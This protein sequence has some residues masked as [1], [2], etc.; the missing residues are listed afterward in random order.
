MAGP[1]DKINKL[2]KGLKNVDTSSAK[3]KK[4][5]DK[6]GK[7][8]NKIGTD[9]RTLKTNQEALVKQVKELADLYGKDFKSQAQKANQEINKQSAINQKIVDSN[10]KLISSITS[11]IT[12][13]KERSREE[14][15]AINMVLKQK[16][17]EEAERKREIASQKRLAA[18]RKKALEPLILARRRAER[19]G[20]AFTKGTKVQIEYNRALKNGGIIQKEYVRELNRL[21]AAE[22]R[23]RAQKSSLTE[24]QKRLNSSLGLGIRN[25]RNG[26]Q[27][28]SVFRSKL[29]LASFGVGLLSKATVDQ[30][31]A[32]GR[33]EGALRR[34]N[35]T[36]ISTGR[37]TKISGQEIQSYAG[38]LQKLTGVSDE[39]IMESS[40]LLLTFTN[41][42]E[43][44]KRAQ[45]VILDV[46]TALGQDLKS[47]TIQV[48]KALQDP[49]KGLSALSRVGIQ[50]TEVQK[51]QIIGFEQVG[52]TA[53]A[54]EVILKELEVQFG[55]LS[56][57]MRDTAE[58]QLLA[59][60]S[61]IGD[62]QEKIG[63]A[64]APTLIEATKALTKFVEGISADSISKVIGFATAIITV[65]AQFKIINV[66]FGKVIPLVKGLTFSFKALTA[67]MGGP[68][69]IAVKA[70]ALGVGALGFNMA[71]NATEVKKTNHTL[72][73]LKKHSDNARS[74][75]QIMLA[76]VGLEKTK[77][78]I[79]E[80]EADVKLLS[81][82]IGI[83]A[84]AAFGKLKNTNEKM[85]SSVKAINTMFQEGNVKAHGYGTELLKLVGIQFGSIT[86]KDLEKLEK[87]GLL[88]L[89]NQIK[90]LKKEQKDVEKFSR[91][92]EQILANP[93]FKGK[94]AKEF[95]LFFNAQDKLKKVMTKSE[96]T[97][98]RTGNEIDTYS[99]KNVDL[100]VATERLNI[101]TQMQIQNLGKIDE[102][103]QELINQ[104]AEKTVAMKKEQLVL[105]NQAQI[106]AQTTKAI[107][108]TTQAIDASSQATLGETLRVERA[109]AIRSKF[110]GKLGIEE[111]QLLELIEAMEDLA[112]AQ[113]LLSLDKEIKQLDG[114]AKV[115]RDNIKASDAFLQIEQRINDEKRK[116]LLD[117]QELKDLR[118]SLVKSTN[119]NQLRGF[120][121]Q[122][123]ALH[124][125]LVLTRRGIKLGGEEAQLSQMRIDMSSQL[126]DGNKE[127]ELAIEDIIQKQK[128]LNAEIRVQR[129]EEEIMQQ[130]RQSGQTFA[131][132]TIGATVSDTSLDVLDE[133]LAINSE[134]V[135]I[136]E[137]TLK[138]SLQK[139]ENQKQLIELE[140][141]AN[142]ISEQNIR[143]LADGT[144]L[145]G[146]K[147]IKQREVLDALGQEA[148]FLN[149]IKQQLNILGLSEIKRNDLVIQ[150]R[151]SL[152]EEQ[153]HLMKL[154]SVLSPDSTDSAI[155][156]RLK[157]LEALLSEGSIEASI[158]AI[159]KGLTS[160]SNIDLSI[161]ESSISPF[162]DTLSKINNATISLIGTRSQ[163][164]IDA[165]NAALDAEIEAEKAKESFKRSSARRQQRIL[166]ALESAQQAKRKKNFDDQKK[167]D[168]ANAKTSGYAAILSALAT[169]PWY[170]GLINAGIAGVMMDENIQQ[171]KATEFALGGFING[172][173]HSMGGVPIEAE[174]GEYIIRKSAVQQYGKEFF[175]S[176]NR[177]QS[178]VSGVPMYQNGGM[179]PRNVTSAPAQNTVI[180][181]QFSGNVLSEEFIVSEAIPIIK[182]S[183]RQSRFMMRTEDSNEYIEVVD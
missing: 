83:R 134:L 138:L 118:E 23:A 126:I 164:S 44:F 74:A 129:L 71:R 29:L 38:E 157:E 8:L 133:L 108:N 141:T 18:Q 139:I 178:T 96:Q 69:L 105:K 82:T 162:L 51:R 45:S 14:T 27:A 35:S 32:F 91:E 52:E 154:K 4:S 56:A 109:N 61:A 130:N 90:Q 143:I 135:G 121:L 67:V 86:K 22:E 34:V 175:D 137:D 158:D 125:Q 26:G 179:V 182:D 55:M 171:I 64:L 77:E 48:G 79:S 117:E 111:K 102:D 5:V 41:V 13:Q 49:I 128:Q 98:Q 89:V 75:L 101:A 68:A 70:I 142:I 20:I 2:D 131:G 21:T 172:P 177:G 25:T 124:S 140:K 170:L 11:L 132:I 180:N 16:K 136:D 57:M 73:E 149:K 148:T 92:L 174:G 104:I 65:I 72:V 166:D 58:G 155:D 145:T 1:I 144:V 85:M 115:L 80:M 9:E 62:L 3:A 122:S 163:A 7:A 176:I 167:L 30:V 81:S 36:I 31:K 43:N 146:E 113:A 161:L 169:K 95:E 6:F 181:V 151:A 94:T 116:G 15:Q 173:S 19:A 107:V 37:L 103:T 119:A 53:K 59:L 10:K 147:A 76:D 112:V 87:T 63:E 123:Q 165:S 33:Q 42:E 88:D 60:D 114:R 159:S 66:I 153:K 152:E 46:S 160:M 39:V 156:V 168:L 47:S 78:T 17:K 12:L 150:R 110:I 54:Q 50:F 40:A 28:F 120:K 183:I 24:G 99:D 100:M 127:L 106:E 93:D 97:I 84:I